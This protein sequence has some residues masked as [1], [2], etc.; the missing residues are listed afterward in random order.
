M[1]NC[2]MRICGSADKSSSSRGNVERCQAKQTVLTDLS[3]L[4]IDGGGGVGGGGHTAFI[5]KGRWTALALAV[6]V[7]MS[8][9]PH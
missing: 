9:Y 5:T 7:Y 6:S 8:A 4:L 2:T 3:V 1:R